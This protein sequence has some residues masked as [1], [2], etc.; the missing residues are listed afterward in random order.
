VEV[1]KHRQILLN[2]NDLSY[3]LTDC[4]IGR[5]YHITVTA[6]T[7]HACCQG[8]II[9]DKTGLSASKLLSDTGY[10]ADTEASHL[11]TPSKSHKFEEQIS[12]HDLKPSLRSKYPGCL[13]SQPLT[14][15]YSQFVLPPM[16]LTVRE[17]H[18]NSAILSWTKGKPHH[19]K[20]HRSKEQKW[21]SMP[22]KMTKHLLDPEKFV[23]RWW[24][25]GSVDGAER[26]ETEREHKNET[27]VCQTVVK[28]S[29]D[30]SHTAV[31]CPLEMQTKYCVTVESQ[32]R[33]YTSPHTT[34]HLTLKAQSE[35]F[36]FHSAQLPGCVSD[37]QIAAVSFTLIFLRWSLPVEKGIAVKCL[38]ID[39]LS[40]DGV[41][42]DQKFVTLPTATCCFESL[43]P[44]SQYM[45]TVYSHTRT[46]DEMK[47]DQMSFTKYTPPSVS[48]VAST[49]GLTP[50]SKL[51]IT[52]RTSELAYLSW[53]PAI[54][55]GPAFV[56][57][58]IVQWQ[59]TTKSAKRQI[60]SERSHFALEAISMQD[61]QIDE[62]W[63]SEVVS[64]EDYTHTIQGLIAG[65]TYCVRVVTVLKP[66][67][68][69]PDVCDDSDRP[70]ANCST[71]WY[72]GDSVIFQSPVTVGK[73]R[74]L[75][76]AY[77]A[78]DIQLYWPKPCMRVP[79]KVDN[80]G[81]IMDKT[82]DTMYNPCYKG[83]AS[84]LMSYRVKVNGSL[85]AT[86][87]NEQNKY[88]VTGRQPGSDSHLQLEALS[89]GE[90]TK[91]RKGIQGRKDGGIL[92]NDY[93]I[94]TS[95][96]IT[97]SMPKVEKCPILTLAC[98][99]VPSSAS[100]E[101]GMPQFE[102]QEN[103][104]VDYAPGVIAV[105]WQVNSKM[106]SSTVK[107]LIV[108]WSSDKNPILKSVSLPANTHCYDIQSLI[109]R[110]VYSVNIKAVLLEGADS[111]MSSAVH[112]QVPG[113][114][115]PP[116][117]WLHAVTENNFTIAW[118]EPQ[119][120]G[121]VMIS[122]YQTYVNGK[123]TGNLLETAHRRAVIPCKRHKQYEITMVAISNSAIFGDSAPS[124]P[125]IVNGMDLF[126]AQKQL[127][128]PKKV[129]FADG[130]D[131]K[132]EQ[133]SD[134]ISTSSLHNK[135]D[136][137]K[138]MGKESLR[139]LVLKVKCKEVTGD[140]ISL[141][142]SDFISLDDIICYE[143][144]WSSVFSPSLKKVVVGADKHFHRLTDCQMGTSYFIR[145]V[146]LGDKNVELARSK[147]LTIQTAALSDP[148][149]LTL[150]DVSGCNVVLEWQQ[151]ELFGP[152]HLI[153]YK[154]QIE[155][156][157]KCQEIELNSSSTRYHMKCKPC[158]LYTFRVKGVTA[159]CGDG[160][161]SPSVSVTCDGV[162]PSPLTVVPT[163]MVSTVK[164]HWDPPIMH[165]NIKI[166]AYKI[167]W[168][169]DSDSESS[170][171]H[172]PVSQVIENHAVICHGP[173]D[174]ST[175]EDKLENVPSA[176]YC[177]VVAAIYSSQAEV[178]Y[179]L[180]LKSY[181]ARPPMPP[182]I[183]ITVVNL[184][185]RKRLETLARRLVSQRDSLQLKLHWQKSKQSRKVAKKR[186][187]ELSRLA[188]SLAAN[189]KE[190]SSC[191]RSLQQQTGNRHR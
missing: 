19:Q 144:Q 186:E 182:T 61:V 45:I 149:T 76:T 111:Y 108:Q 71:F 158:E 42:M 48:I 75:V 94:S 66:T 91:K 29:D 21:S 105:E 60:S 126:A 141:D 32:A 28:V 148:P 169:I 14:V 162:V 54:P 152:T 33:L 36:E 97:V 172:I 82:E 177:W 191:L 89:C 129:Q 55:H 125:L 90:G 122:A 154:L 168:L 20:M 53:S 119:T 156:D 85:F 138:R 18:A 127:A 16:N 164:V 17:L 128:I 118:S 31:L 146:A 104:S 64:C 109:Q 83:V 15:S 79:V 52:S 153:G 143:V 176:G 46:K 173:L 39:L 163:G 11:V 93:G 34:R 96:E 135:K 1:N 178:A 41:V 49:L 59:E 4:E 22:K 77:T 7:E 150:K 78:T 147:Q 86:L 101:I 13:P 44:N 68:A 98:H 87:G 40:M 103:E 123:K 189:E 37:L 113:S 117:L 8:N 188:R 112:C 26:D 167:F 72:I 120:Y 132:S 43:Q 95:D 107:K 160:P 142:W 80:Q 175:S 58:Y 185:Q 106:S 99:F 165:G 166:R 74:L 130:T 140:T 27:V 121:S 56:Q 184:S 100:F 88:I 5:K 170:A 116:K 161:Y 155:Y 6:L 134:S 25:H 38:E 35:P 174:P 133:P 12:T 137:Q 171:T 183:A 23:V 9:A 57:Q 70:E 131:D 151:P 157:D 50:A 3:C 136:R 92:S 181:P 145:V 2:E 10:E 73:P 179:S 115:D 102:N 51:Q 124:C 24:K 159:E 84:I 190:L 30:D 67:V 114:P 63:S 110:D 69:S 47:H 187:M 65:L 62:K 81:M 180:P 139:R